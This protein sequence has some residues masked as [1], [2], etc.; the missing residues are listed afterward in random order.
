MWGILVFARAGNAL[1]AW[2]NII[3]S[4]IIFFG[5]N[6][7]SDKD[8]VENLFQKFLETRREVQRGIDE[9]FELLRREPLDRDAIAKT[10]AYLVSDVKKLVELIDAVGEYIDNVKDKTGYQEMFNR[11]PPALAVIFAILIALSESP[12]TLKNSIEQCLSDLKH[13]FDKIPKRYSFGSYVYLNNYIKNE[14]YNKLT[15]LLEHLKILYV[16]ME[17]EL[18]KTGYPTVKSIP[19]ISVLDLIMFRVSD[20]PG[21]D[22]KWV[23]AAIYLASLEV[24]IN[25]VCSELNIKANTFKDKLDNLVQYMKKHSI[26]V[27]KIEKDIVS[28]LYDYRNKVLHGGYVPTDEELHYI[29][30]VVPK[31]IQ[32]IKEIRLRRLKL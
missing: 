24:C 10:L 14:L 17:R 22:D 18:Y 6:I 12:R 2:L 30:L 27:S 25:N 28:R 29:T 9:A 21:L 16:R 32:L 23:C 3:V 4:L 20:W 8:V 7:L 11:L 13:I 31:F 19:I 15:T 5:A 26:K 1:K